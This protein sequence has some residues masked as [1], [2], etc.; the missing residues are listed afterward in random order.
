MIDTE[1]FVQFC[2]TMLAVPQVER[3][4]LLK[5]YNPVYLRDVLEKASISTVYMLFE[6]NEAA[7]QTILYY[8]SD[9]Y[10]SNIIDSFQTKINKA[11][12]SYKIKL[13]NGEELIYPT[14][15]DIDREKALNVIFHV[16]ENGC[17]HPK[18]LLFIGANQIEFMEVL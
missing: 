6:D 15:G 9:K 14:S 12:K 3:K 17:T 8:F 18:S 16:M 4:A 2:R 11:F 7:I 13:K 1:R 5:M 10:L